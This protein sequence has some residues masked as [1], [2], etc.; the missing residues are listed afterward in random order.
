MK[1]LVIYPD[2]FSIKP[3][4]EVTVA[5]SNL[6]NTA[7]ENAKPKNL[8]LE[9]G[10]YVF[11]SKY[12][13]ERELYISNTIG[14]KEYSETDKKHIADKQK[15]TTDVTVPFNKPLSEFLYFLKLTQILV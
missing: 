10:N 11:L 4:S 2:S 6:L 1:I 9:K 7:S 15:A 8:L 13:N 14:D 3:D 12:A 5:F